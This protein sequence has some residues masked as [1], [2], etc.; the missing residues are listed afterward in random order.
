MEL[1]I[2]PIIPPLDIVAMLRKLADKLESGE[3]DF[4]RLTIITSKG[5]VLNFGSNQ[6]ECALHSVFDCQLAIQKILQPCLST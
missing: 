3:E 1:K 4:S 2:V 6:E 5:D